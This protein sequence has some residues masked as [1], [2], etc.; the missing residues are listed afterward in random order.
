MATHLS[1]V[2]SCI[3]SSH[4]NWTCLILRFCDGVSMHSAL[5]LLVKTIEKTGISLRLKIYLYPCGG[6]GGGGQKAY[7]DHCSIGKTA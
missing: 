2:H 1:P 7:T 3:A 5:I 6:E 4:K